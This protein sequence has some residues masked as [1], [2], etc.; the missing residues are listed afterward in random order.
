MDA[1]RALE[2]LVVILADD[3]LRDRFLALTG[4]DGDSLRARLGQ[5]DLAA[6]VESFLAGHEPDLIRVA[7]ALGVAPEMLL[8]RP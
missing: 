1:S 7:A 5:P 8:G 6:A 3:R 4:H 2:A